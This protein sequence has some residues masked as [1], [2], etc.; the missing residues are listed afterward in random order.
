MLILLL[1]SV[2]WCVCLYIRLP[3][4]KLEVHNIADPQYYTFFPL[5]YFFAGGLYALQY[6]YISSVHML[7]VYHSFEPEKSPCVCMKIRLIDPALLSFTAV[8]RVWMVLSIILYTCKN[9]G[10]VC[11]LSLDWL[12]HSLPT[13]SPF[14]HYFT[15]GLLC[16]LS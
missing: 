14:V 7:H 10:A 12:N 9:R 3:V 15:L 4:L 1:S 16:V 2:C 13:I 8:C 11:T 6:Q 5:S